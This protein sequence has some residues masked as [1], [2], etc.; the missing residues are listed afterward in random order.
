MAQALTNLTV[1]NEAR[2][3]LRSVRECAGKA[4]GFGDL[5][6]QLERAA[7]SVASNIAE[8]AGSGSDRRFAYFLRIARGSVN[9]VEAQLLLLTDIGKLPQQHPAIAAANLLGRRLTCFIN[10]LDGGGG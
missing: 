9:E 7:I 6:N 2:A 5:T 8:G 10:R 3:L 1:F 4:G